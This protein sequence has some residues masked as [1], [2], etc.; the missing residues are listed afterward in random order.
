VCNIIIFGGAGYL[1]GALVD[2]LSMNKEY[3]VTVYDS[4]LYETRYLKNVN[5]VYGD[6]RD[7]S[8]ISKL[9]ELNDIII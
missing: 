4:L 5:F 3:A 2:F 7:W 9:V 6:I 1:G 8:K